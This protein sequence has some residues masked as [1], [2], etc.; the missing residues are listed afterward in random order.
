MPAL[1]AAGLASSTST[2]HK[3]SVAICVDVEV[4]Q[5]SSEDSRHLVDRGVERECDLHPED[6]IY[7][8]F[9]QCCDL[10]VLLPS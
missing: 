8:F 10:T 3:A 1:L 2:Q 6:A 7:L 4:D 5:A 9:L